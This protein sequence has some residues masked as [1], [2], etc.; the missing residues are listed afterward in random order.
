MEFWKTTVLTRQAC[1]EPIAGGMVLDYQG[2]GL[3]DGDA[4]AAIAFCRAKMANK[5]SHGVF[6]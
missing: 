6:T 1:D 5:V 3:V 2:E 4:K